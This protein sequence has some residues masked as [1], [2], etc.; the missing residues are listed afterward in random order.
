MIKRLILVLLLFSILFFTG[1]SY[2]TNFFIIN[3]TDSTIKIEYKVRDLNSVVCFVPFSKITEEKNKRKIFRS[4][5]IIEVDSSKNTIVKFLKKGQSL[6][7]GDDINFS[8]NDP[9]D[10][11]KLKKNLVYLKIRAANSKINADSSNVENLFKTIDRY[12]VSIEVK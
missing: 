10:K 12:N 2:L 1:C 6:W 8:M 9:Y 3:N 5:S 7:I 11:N 4:D